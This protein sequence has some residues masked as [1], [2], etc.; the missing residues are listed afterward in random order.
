[1]TAKGRL[2]GMGRIYD[3]LP[4]HGGYVLAV[5]ADGTESTSWPR[6]EGHG[7]VVAHRAGCDCGFRG[8]LHEGIDDTDPPYASDDGPGDELMEVWEVHVGDL[9]SLSAL[10]EAHR[11]HE[12]A[13]SRLIRAVATARSAGRTWPEIAKVLGV[14]KQ[15]VHER[16]AKAVEGLDPRLIRSPDERLRPMRVLNG[17]DIDDQNVWR[18]KAHPEKRIVLDRVLVVGR[19]V[20]NDH[21]ADLSGSDALTSAELE[22]FFTEW[23]PVPSQSQT[24]L[25][26]Q[27]V[28]SQA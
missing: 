3:D 27:G 21:G 16:F 4:D 12:D 7:P 19:V 2:D 13:H 25:P 23:E 17:I 22:L 24:R 18:S 10:A 14:S 20:S 11:A 6:P 28:P 1:M 8:P 26:A 15:A 5:L 9:R